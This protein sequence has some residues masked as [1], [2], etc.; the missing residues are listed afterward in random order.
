MKTTIKGI[1]C[2][3]ATLAVGKFMFDLPLQWPH[4]VVAVLT[5]GWAMREE[6]R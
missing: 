6:L 1:V 5:L 3:A 2:L 4:V